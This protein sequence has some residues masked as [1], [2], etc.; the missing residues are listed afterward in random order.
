MGK[1]DLLDFNMS[2]LNQF[3]SESKD[4]RRYVFNTVKLNEAFSNLYYTGGIIFKDNCG[5]VILSE[6]T[7]LHN[8]FL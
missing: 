4:L 2:A 8:Y 6:S 1:F 3:L 5:F 7:L